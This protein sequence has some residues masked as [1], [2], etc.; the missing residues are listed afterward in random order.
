MYHRKGKFWELKSKAWLTRLPGHFRWQC[1]EN[2][3]YTLA[4][5]YNSY[6]ISLAESNQY[7]N[8]LSTFGYQL[9]VCSFSTADDN[10]FQVLDSRG[11]PLIVEVARQWSSLEAGE[12]GERPKCV[13]CGCLLNVANQ[14]GEWC[15]RVCGN[16]NDL[17]F[18]SRPSQ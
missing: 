15:S 5:V 1:C 7:L 8:S 6:D 9:E 18:V 12:G 4:R 13:A 3:G 10:R 11:C 14:N 16:W 17:S 2:L